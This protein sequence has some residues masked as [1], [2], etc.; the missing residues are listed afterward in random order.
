MRP[1]PC[2]WRGFSLVRRR[3][4]V[5]RWEYRCGAILIRGGSL[6]SI[7]KHFSLSV[8]LLLIWKARRVVETINIVCLSHKVNAMGLYE[9]EEIR[10]AYSLD[11]QWVFSRMKSYLLILS[12]LYYSLIIWT[13][14]FGY[15]PYL[16]RGDIL[17]VSNVQFNI[18]EY[19]WLAWRS[20]IRVKNLTFIIWLIYWWFMRL[21]LPCMLLHL[22]R[23]ISLIPICVNSLRKRLM[24]GKL[25]LLLQDLCEKF[26]HI[27]FWR[28]VFGNSRFYNIVKYLLQLL[29]SLLFMLICLKCVRS[30]RGHVNRPRHLSIMLGKG[31]QLLNILI[32]WSWSYLRRSHYW[33]LVH[34]EGPRDL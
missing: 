21:I 32:W 14:E 13:W 26:S 6:L 23:I 18:F 19:I 34:W 4:V 17:H 11:L 9:V 29:R 33:N 30:V 1:V 5:M 7:D 12:Y 20:E 15:N 25:D 3:L 10:G 8:K 16:S 2:L 24:F 28:F 31:V 22:I 27:L